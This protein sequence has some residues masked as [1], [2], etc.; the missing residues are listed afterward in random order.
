MKTLRNLRESEN[1]VKSER[2]SLTPEIP[3]WM[4]AREVPRDP[5]DPE[6]IPQG[7][8][9]AREAPRDPPQILR[10][11]PRDDLALWRVSDRSGYRQKQHACTQ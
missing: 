4:V 6:E 10:R 11:S 5:R 1:L 9:V 2:E 3:R 7:W 8:M